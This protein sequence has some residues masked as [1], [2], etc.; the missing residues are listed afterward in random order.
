MFHKQALLSWLLIYKHNFSLHRYLSWNNKDIKYK[1]S[2]I[3]V[4]FWQLGKK[5]ILL[6]TQ[7][8]KEDRTLCSHTELVAK[9]GFSLTQRQLSIVSN[10][11][12]LGV[13]RLLQSLL[14]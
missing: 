8:L 14:L 3:R 10:A 5:M 9:H 2:F 1:S 6:V 4:I 11:I 12:P 13:L 7:L